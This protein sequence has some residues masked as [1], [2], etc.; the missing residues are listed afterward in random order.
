MSAAATDVVVRTRRIIAL[1]AGIGVILAA[2]FYLG[3]GMREALSA[4]CG[5]VIGMLLVYHLSRGV[6]RAA[7]A[8]QHSRGLSMGILYVGA[9]VRFLLVL[10]LFAVALGWF[11]LAPLPTVIGFIAAQL[12]NLTNARGKRRAD[13]SNN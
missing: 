4:L 8:A 13:V 11:K 9:M 1:Q 12:A 6:V 10:V 7:E 5:G 2:G 3:A